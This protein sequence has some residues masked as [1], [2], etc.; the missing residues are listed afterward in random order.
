MGGSDLQRGVICHHGAESFPE[1]EGI[2]DEDEGS[3]ETVTPVYD[4]GEGRGVKK[5]T[6]ANPDLTL[7]HLLAANSAEG[8]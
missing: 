6:T 5:V 8:P 7:F 3:Y 1:V 4:A 2:K